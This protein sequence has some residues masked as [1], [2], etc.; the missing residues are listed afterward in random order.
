MRKII[1]DCD[2]G[3][4]DLVALV[5][6]MSREDVEILGIT[7]VAGNQLLDICTK[8]ALA[9]TH[10][11]GKQ[12]SVHAGANA[13][14]MREQVIADEIHGENG[15][16]NVVLQEGIAKVEEES[17]FSFLNRMAQKYPQELEVIA[18]GPLTNIA[19]TI[20]TYP[21]FAKNVK[22]ISIM[23]GGHEKGNVTPA[24]EFNFYADPEAAKAVFESGIPLIMC[25]LDITMCEGL[26]DADIKRLMEGKK[27]A[28][29]KRI[30]TALQ[31]ILEIGIR[32]GYKYAFVHD[33]IAA[34]ALLEEE[35]AKGDCYHVD[36]E[37]KGELTYGKSV[38]DMEHI[39]GKEKHVF[40]GFSFEK[41]K[42]MQEM[43]RMIAYYEV[44]ER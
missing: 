32:F 4:D 28:C 16:G 11:F 29:N 18:I 30:E 9:I 26:D 2:P 25:G 23:G 43:Q 3:I 37:T 27:S 10:T 12:I 33:L 24:A 21:E 41:E 8:N 17:A 35:F 5:N 13:P 20:R 1:V 31:D 44:L 38:V 42:L 19:L 39:T 36:I 15:V 34:I 22:R 6:V 40:V 7:T 14:L